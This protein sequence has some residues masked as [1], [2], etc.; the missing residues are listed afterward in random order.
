MWLFVG[1]CGN[2]SVGGII[3]LQINIR[4]GGEIWI[5]ILII[6]QSL[7]N[8]LLQNIPGW[9]GPGK[10]KDISSF[11]FWE[12]AAVDILQVVARACSFQPRNSR[13]IVLTIVNQW[14]IISYHSVPYHIISYCIIL[15]R[16]DRIVKDFLEF[17]Q[18]CKPPMF[19][20]NTRESRF[21]EINCSAIFLN[22]VFTEK[23]SFFSIVILTSPESCF[24]QPVERILTTFVWNAAARLKKLEK[25]LIFVC[26]C[27]LP[28]E[29]PGKL[30][31]LPDRPP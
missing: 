2:S 20:R 15:Y 18:T 23:T 24:S 7:L 30:K 3:M 25:K 12:P 31:T 4:E 29:P 16:W 21:S 22:L 26:L 1:K 27:V 19:Q 17:T 9:I 14:D 13:R 10:A 8:I 11:M 6:L 28:T 5:S